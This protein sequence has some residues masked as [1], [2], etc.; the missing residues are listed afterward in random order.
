M[1]NNYLLILIAN[2]ICNF[3]QIFTFQHLILQLILTADFL[4]IIIKDGY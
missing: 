2:P 3:V 4:T 1:D